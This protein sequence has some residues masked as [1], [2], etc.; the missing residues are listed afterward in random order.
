MRTAIFNLDETLIDG[1]VIDNLA[2]KYGFYYDL[3]RLRTNLRNGLMSHEQVTRATIKLLKGRRVD[4][5]IHMVKSMSLMPNSRK[6]LNSLKSKGF[7]LGIISDELNIITDSF[8]E[9]FELD[10]SIGHKTQIK[11]GKLA[12]RVYLA[13]HKGKYVNWKKEKI[14]EIRNKTN[15]NI[16]AIGKGDIDAPML[17][18]AEVGIAFNATAKAQK[19][20]DIIVNGKD[21][22][23]VL[24]VIDKTTL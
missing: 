3:N 22:K 19:A 14:K 21:M 24:D 1:R 18:E 5:I 13:P 15:S 10:Y 6:M 11:N 17:K 16:I 20:S 7:K 12:G 2:L 23:K 4:E 9:R 8:A